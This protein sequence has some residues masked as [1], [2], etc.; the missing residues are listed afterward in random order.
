[1]VKMLM[2]HVIYLSELLGIHLIL[3]RLVVFLDN[4]FLIL[5][6]FMLHL[7]MSLFGVIC[8]IRLTMPLVR[9]LVIHGVTNLT[10]YHP[11]TILMLS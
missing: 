1:M 11:R 6:H 7:I 3:R 8:V 5:V 10:L 2:I 4:H 9:V